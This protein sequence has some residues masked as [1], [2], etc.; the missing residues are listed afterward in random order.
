MIVSLCRFAQVFGN[1]AEL[2]QGRFQLFHDFFSDDVRIGEVFC[3]FQRLVPQPKNVEID[4]VP[5]HDIVQGVSSPATVGVFPVPGR[6]PFVTV[7]RIEASHKLVQVGAGEGVLLE[8]VVD[9]GTVVVEPDL[10]CPGPFPT[11]LAVEEKDV[12][13]NP[14]GIK[15]AGRQAQDGVQVAFLQQLAPHRLPRAA[16]KEHVVRHHY[17]RFPMDLQQLMD[18]LHKI[19]LLVAGRSPEVVANHGLRFPLHFAFFGDV[20]DAGLFTKGRVGQNHVV[21][22]AGF[23]G[24]GVIHA[25]GAAVIVVADAMQVQIH[26]TEAGGI[27]D[28]FPT[29]QRILPQMQPLVAVQLVVLADEIISGQEEAASAAGRIADGCCLVGA[30]SHRPWPG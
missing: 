9:V 5:G 13:L 27:V 21:G 4:L 20:G 3:V 7:S 19:Q 29:V 28:D 10:F 25:D 14:L 24:Q 8:R 2:F 22:I 15:D 26:D 1:Q 11:R 17:C 30:A 6:Y 12:G 18:V 16:F 23:I